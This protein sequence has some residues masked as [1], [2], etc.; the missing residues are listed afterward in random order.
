MRRQLNPIL[1]NLIKHYLFLEKDIIMVPAIVFHSSILAKFI[2][3]KSGTHFN[4]TKYY[5]AVVNSN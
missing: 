2:P 3:L 1:P 4:S 5:W